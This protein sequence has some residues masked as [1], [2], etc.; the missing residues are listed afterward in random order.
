MYVI[1][2]GGGD[3]GIQLAKRLIARDHE[4]LMIEKEASQA[5]RLANLLGDQ[6]VMMGDAC[7]LL[8]Q[9]TSGFA[10]ADVVVA[11][12]GE[13]ED[14]L[15]CCQL[16]KEVWK[17][18]RLIAR[19]N[20]PAHEEVFRKLG[21]DDTVSAT[22]I[23]FGMIDQQISSD[24]LIPVG[25]LHKGAVEVVESELSDESPLIGVAVRDVKL[26]QGTYIVYILRNGVGMRVDGDTEFQVGDLVVAIVPVARAEGLRAVLRE[27]S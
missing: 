16:A 18:K 24:E 12:T 1:V 4:V 20:D 13:D 5:T 17:V 7:D 15:I 3:V 6:H 2:V 9:K 14:N 26:P 8:T 21:I 19:V 25:N 10:R 27:K 11:V 23:L 22:R